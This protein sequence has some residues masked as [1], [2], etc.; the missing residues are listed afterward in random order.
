MPK[1]VDIV[2]STAAAPSVS[3][4]EHQKL[5]TMYKELRAR[6]KDFASLLNCSLESSVQSKPDA[7]LGAKSDHRGARP[8]QKK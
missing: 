1:T 6:H 8:K 4:D 3:A 2:A 5:Q 7:A